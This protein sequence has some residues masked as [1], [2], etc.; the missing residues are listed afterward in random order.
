MSRFTTQRNFGFGKQMDWAGHQALKDIYGRGHFG[1]VASHAQRWRQFCRWARSTYGINDACTINQLILDNYAAD[2]AERVEDETLAVSYAQNLIVSVNITL[3]ALRQDKAIRI[4]SPASWVGKRQTVRTRVPDG[5]DWSDID[6]LVARLRAKKLQRAAVI[7]LLCR[8]IGIRL[9]EAILANYADWQ[10]Q[11][12]ERGQ[13]DIREGTKGGRG[14]EVARWVPVSERGLL[15]IREAVH[16]RNQLGGQNLLK[17][18]E[19]FDDLVNA[20]EVHRARKVL[21]EFGVKGYHE[22]RAAWACERYEEISGAT[23]PVV[24]AGTSLGQENDDSFRLI[25]ARE[26]G[27]D[28]IDVV[29]AYIGARP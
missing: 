19:N 21:H 3:E 28:R 8:S 27:H 14:K 10:R 9:R 24:Q 29:V 25:L 12:M 17:P 5:M 2:L 13:I 18:D 11:S 23:A 22:L 20:G 1:T 7:V 6:H 4:E 16:A 26:L 15:A